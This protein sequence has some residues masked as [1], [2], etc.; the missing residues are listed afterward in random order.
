MMSTSGRF[1]DA[2]RTSRRKFLK[3]SA[4]AVS[5]AAFSG[6][7]VNLVAHAAGSDVIRIGMVGCGGRCNGA[8]GDAMSVDPGLRLVAMCDLFMDRVKDSRER[9][10]KS[11]PDQVA[12]DD[13]HCFAGFDGYKNVIQ[14]V[15]AVLIACAA[16]FHPLHMRAAIEAG[17][18]VFV[19]KPHAI[20]PLGVKAVIAACDLARQKN[21]S[22][23]S[24][25]QSRFHTGYQEAIKRIHDGA[26]GDVVAIEE[27]FLRP[28][29]VLVK[30]APGLNEVQYQCSNQYHFNWLSGDDVPQSLIHNVDRSLWAMREQVPV[31]CHGLAGRSAMFDEIYGN[32]FDHHSVIYEFAG[33]AKLYAFCRTTTGCYN[34]VS[35]LILGTKGRCN[36]LACRIEG[37]TKWQHQGPKCNPY[38]EEHR[39]LFQAIR[40]GKP[41]NS[42]DYM[43]NATLATVMGQLSCYTGKEV[44]WDQAAKSDFF[45]PP[46]SEGCSFDMEPPVKPGPNGQYPV[47]VPGQT[48]LL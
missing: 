3:T 47:Y 41:I 28:P 23:V 15:D 31:K 20:D 12:V 30:R 27:N 21:L 34:E 13:D 25:L 38:Q 40:A 32:V 29:Y 2:G 18:H 14:S 22:V 24:G 16:K 26:I 44:T 19:E 36:L 9:L 17:K 11:R 10:K 35:S 7:A 43:V 45:Y 33:G 4:M 5:G 46:P 8:A 1:S 39:A 48:T 37:E 42:R 6:L